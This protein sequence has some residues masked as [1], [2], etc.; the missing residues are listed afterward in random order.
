MTGAGGGTATPLIWIK[1]A[2]LA[3]DGN[4]RRIPLKKL[5]FGKPKPAWGNEDSMILQ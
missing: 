5:A 4:C 3:S 2:I 1:R